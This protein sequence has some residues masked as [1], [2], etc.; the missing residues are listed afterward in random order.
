VII[1]LPAELPFDGGVALKRGQT[2]IGLAEG[3]S[4]PSITNT[5][6]ERNG[7][8]GVVLADDCRVLNIR[9]VRPV[10]SGILGVDVRGVSLVG[11]EVEG[12]NRSAGFTSFEASVLGR[13]A[14]GG[15]L[16]VA[17]RPGRALEN[18]V[19]DCTVTNA[20]G[21]GI[22]SFALGGA[23]SRLFVSHTHSVGGAPIPPLFDMGVVA[24]ADGRQSEMHLEMDAA[25]VSGRLNRQGRNVVV[26][27]SA[28]AKATARIVRSTLGETGQDG[29][30]AVAAL[31]PATVAVEIRDSTIEKA[32]QM[33]IEGTILNLPPSDP[34]RA[35]ESVVT[36]DV[37][38][39]VIRDVGAVDG[40]RNEAQN[41]WLGP[42]FF[43]QGPFARGRYRLSIRNSTVE[44]ALK[45]GIGLG[46]EGS[47][48]KIAPDDGEYEV[49]L[50][51]NT[52]RG[53]GA[54]EISVS[55]LNARIDARQNWWGVP[56]GFAV[57]RRLLR[58]KSKRSQLD[59]S[60]PLSSPPADAK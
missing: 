55:A 9:V 16:F 57:N 33:N 6:T 38:G 13:I 34:A 27:A 22:G 10:S 37:E 18:R 42:T 14:H 19:V 44:K 2:L 52:I 8:N 29:V 48:F 53:N 21:L 59:A 49:L 3:H 31:V 26:F 50:R 40:F 15:V 54:S 32:G 60:E 43:G 45:T 46:N 20:A 28:G 11:V 51:N 5:G 25:T 58:E 12:A 1:V 7:G 36:I 23:Q 39:S 35:H 56:E 4:L 47:E 30:V 41:I 17:T 24:L